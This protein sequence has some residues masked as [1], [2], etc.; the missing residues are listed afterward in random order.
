M[1]QGYK[2][3]DNLIT[4]HEKKILGLAKDRETCLR[5]VEELE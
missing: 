4:L 2:A 3:K 1:N 5:A